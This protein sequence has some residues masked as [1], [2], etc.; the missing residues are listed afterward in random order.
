MLIGAGRPWSFDPHIA[1]SDSGA[2]S[3]KP[4]AKRSAPAP[5]DPVAMAAGTP[6]DGA[7]LHEHRLAVNRKID[8]NVVLAAIDRRLAKKP[9][10]GCVALRR[11]VAEGG[12]VQTGAIN[13]DHPAVV[14]WIFTDRKKTDQH[15]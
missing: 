14:A 1:F 15:G 9:A 8:R 6:N 11:L 2:P 7:V 10:E 3:G 13:N 12:L 4:R 5:T